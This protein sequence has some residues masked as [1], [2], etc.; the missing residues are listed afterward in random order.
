MKGKCSLRCRCSTRQRVYSA[1]SSGK[2][3]TSLAQIDEKSEIPPKVQM[4]I[5]QLQT[6][7]Q[8][9]QQQ[10]QQQ[11]MLLKNR[12]DV[13]QVRQQGETQRE[14]MRATVKAHDTESWVAHEN[15]KTELETHTKAHDTSLN[16]KKAIDVEEIKGHIAILL[17]KIDEA[18]MRRAESE[19]AERAI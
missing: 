9:M 8:Q 7:L 16:Y 11:A 19:T 17:A 10:N 14:H 6:Q 5:K 15:R 18:S 3:R 2:P 12:M 4:M 13:E 1:I